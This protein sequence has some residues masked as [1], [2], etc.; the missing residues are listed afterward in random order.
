MRRY[1]SA[2]PEAAERTQARKFTDDLSAETEEND[3]KKLQSRRQRQQEQQL[4]VDGCKAKA[5]MM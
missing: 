4:F 3:E 2:E 1:I 5:G